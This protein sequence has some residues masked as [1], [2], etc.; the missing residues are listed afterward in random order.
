M[1]V[2]PAIAPGAVHAVARAL[3]DELPEVDVERL[4]VAVERVAGRLFAQDA[5]EAIDWERVVDVQ[6]DRVA[7]AEAGPQSA[8]ILRELADD[9]EHAIG[10]P[11]R[12][13]TARLGAFA[14]AASALDLD[15]IVRLARATDRWRELPLDA[16]SAVA[17]CG[18]DE[19]RARWFAGIAEGWEERGDAYRAADCHEWVL[20]GAPGDDRAHDALELFYRAHGE[21]PALIDLLRRRAERVDDGQRA[22]IFRDLGA[23]YERD[24]GDIAAAFD[25]YRLADRLAPERPDVLDALARVAPQVDEHDDALGALVRLARVSADAAPRARALHRAAEIAWRALHDA[26]AAH[27][28]LTRALDADPDFASA[29][30][31]MAALRTERGEL[32]GALELLLDAAKRPALAADRTRLLGDA[33]AICVELGDAARA[34]ELY[35]AVRDAEPAD[36]RAALALAELYWDARNVDD[37]AP[38]LA[39]LSAS[40]HEPRRLHAYLL[41]LAEAATARGDAAIAQDALARALAIDPDDATPRRALAELLFAR[42]ELAAARPLIEALLDEDEAGLPPDACVELHHRAARCARA[43]G[44]DAGAGRHAAIALALDPSHRETLLLRL[45]LDADDPHAQVADQLALAAGAPPE[46]KAARYAALGDLYASRL[47]DP[48]AAREMYREALAHRPHDHVLL[49]KSLGLIAGEGDWSYGLDLAQ[50]LIETEQDAP[51]RAR[52]RQLAAMILR[53]E[54]GRAGDAADELA[55]AV[56]DA[57]LWFEA[58]DDLEALLAR[59]PDAERNLRFYYRRLEQ[60]RGDEGR[61]GELVRLWDK[62]GALCLALGRRDDARCAYE[63]ALSLEP[64]DLPRRRRLAELCVACGSEHFDDAIAHHQA[65]LDETQGRVASYEAL[66]ALYAQTG[67]PSH[68]RACEDAIGILGVRAVPPAIASPASRA[69]TAGTPVPIDPD[70]W[71][72]LSGDVDLQLSALFALVAPVVAVERARLRPP[73]RHVPGL[74]LPDDDRAAARV[75]RRV[76]GA[77]DLARPPVTIDRD[78]AA[79]CRVALRA[80]D[81][82]LAPAVVLGRPALADGVDERA[83]AFTIARRLAD[84]RPDRFARLLCPRA[85]D[86]AQIVDLAQVLALGGAPPTG[87]ARGRAARWLASSL[88]PVALDQVVRLGQ[89]LRDRVDPARAAQAWLEATERAGDRVGLVIAGDLAA[90][91]RALE[92]EPAATSDPRERILALVR[93]SVGEDVLAVRARLERWPAAGATARD[94]AMS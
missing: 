28:L 8:A 71:W 30:D 42:G 34:T 40:T 81:G 49:T 61:P 60:L 23:L 57:P 38:I 65:I 17:R 14:E 52:Y 64:D 46:E 7:D 45:E 89:R 21:W 69:V 16:M 13:L 36:R 70:G 58:A 39:E 6:L 26:D 85:D 15:P 25:A 44:D 93:A 12:A 47:G 41:R 24:L 94:H 33:G 62:L 27:D 75:L 78:Q 32:A 91:V 10:D 18:D 77:L 76:L 22:E 55:R 29:V 37:A 82:A 63:V 31:A 79:A 92:G 88:D 19:S 5:E 56:E 59:Q 74:A 80:I 73:P 48:N 2:S 9:L 84:L 87:D 54:L 35:R 53:D 50:R 67:R 51:V 20:R 66:A 11:D 83:L 86:L 43:L 72:M 68:A 1:P 4:Y 90:C 3:A